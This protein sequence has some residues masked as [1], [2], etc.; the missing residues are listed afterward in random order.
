LSVAKRSILGHLYRDG[1]KTPGALA[2]AEG[3]Q[4]QSLT[5]VFADLEESGFA[6]RQQDELDRRQFKLEITPAGREILERDAG[7]RA[8]W[9]AS[10]M[11]ACLS[12][13]E[14]E[15]L[16]LA[17]QLMDRLA[18]FPSDQRVV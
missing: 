13:T 7:K 4:P 2:I 1:P 8:L 6:L 9:L 12:S 3:V 14:Q 17:A 18:E 15:L 10:A 16:R 11:A 5:R